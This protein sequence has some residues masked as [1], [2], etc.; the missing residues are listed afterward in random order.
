L[1]EV[2]KKMEDYLLENNVSLVSFGSQNP[3]EDIGLDQKIEQIFLGYIKSEK[4]AELMKASDVMLVPS[5]YENYPFVAIESLC[6]GTP[7]VAFKVGGIP[8]IIDEI[9]K[10]YLATPLANEDYLNGIKYVLEHTT[11]S[12]D[13]KFYDISIKGS[14][15]IRLFNDCVKASRG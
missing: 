8:E 2:L 13:N 12:W 15:Y 6:C 3:F 1:T 4:V 10:G 14:E 9:N 11:K 7:V 5:R